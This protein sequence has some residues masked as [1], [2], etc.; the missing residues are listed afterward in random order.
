MA[1]IRR[2]FYPRMDMPLELVAKELDPSDIKDKRTRRSKSFSHNKN[3]TN[4]RR[5]NKENSE[6][7]KCVNKRK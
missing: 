7:N 3:F 5:K 6:I 1:E 2:Q 4:K